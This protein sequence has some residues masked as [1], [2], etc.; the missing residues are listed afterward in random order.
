MRVRWVWKVHHRA[1][2]HDTMK[3]KMQSLRFLMRVWDSGW[4]ACRRGVAWSPLQLCKNTSCW[5]ETGWAQRPKWE[6]EKAL[7]N[8]Q[9]KGGSGLIWRW[10]RLLPICVH[11]SLLPRLA[12]PIAVFCFLQ[13]LPGM[14][15]QGDWCL[16]LF[17]KSINYIFP[18]DYLNNPVRGK[19]LRILSPFDR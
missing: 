8:G 15:G 16:K 5:V 4:R 12:L 9:A 11:S 3:F 14:R 13:V 17:Q 19:K 18:F 7:S 6:F 2:S 1:G 10:Q